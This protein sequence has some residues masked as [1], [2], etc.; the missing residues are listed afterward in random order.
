MYIY[1][2]MFVLGSGQVDPCSLPAA[3]NGESDPAVLSLSPFLSLTH[4]HTHRLE[5]TSR[6]GQLGCRSALQCV[7]ICCSVLQCV[8]SKGNLPTA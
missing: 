6:P 3:K 1:I 5:I 2:H 7:A 4:T 8:A